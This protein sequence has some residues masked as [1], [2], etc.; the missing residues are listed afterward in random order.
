MIFKKKKYYV[1]SDWFTEKF[2]LELITKGFT[3]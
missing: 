2:R 1:V 3:N